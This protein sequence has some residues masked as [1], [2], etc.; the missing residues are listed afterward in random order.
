MRAEQ[1]R[2]AMRSPRQ[3]RALEPRKLRVASPSL[4]G[5]ARESG[6]YLRLDRSASA[7]STSIAALPG[8]SPW[9]LLTSVIV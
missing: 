5:L 7:C 1:L 4:I 8:S 3:A 6:P 9:Q 2:D